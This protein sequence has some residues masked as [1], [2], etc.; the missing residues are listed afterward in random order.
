MPSVRSPTAVA[1]AVAGVVLLVYALLTGGAVIAFA[2][3][4][5]GV[6]AYLLAP[7]AQRRGDDEDDWDDDGDDGPGL[8]PPPGPHEA[9]ARSAA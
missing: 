2:V 9:R 7:Y 5:F 6:T 4:A 8:E 3:E 1:L